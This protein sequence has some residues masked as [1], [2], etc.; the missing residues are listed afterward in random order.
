MTVTDLHG[1][2][3]AVGEIG[4]AHGEIALESLD[5]VREKF[6]TYARA[7]FRD[8]AEC[9]Q[10]LSQLEA[11]NTVGDIGDLVSASVVTHDEILNGR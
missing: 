2:Q 5:E 7:R 3:L 1:R 10:V 6:T 11:L 8:D 9:A 4:G